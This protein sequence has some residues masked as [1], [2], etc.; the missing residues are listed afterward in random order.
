MTKIF[1]LT[2]IVTNEADKVSL[3]EDVLNETHSI[4]KQ[5]VQ[6]QLPLIIDRIVKEEIEKIKKGIQ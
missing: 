2:D 6:E 4:V 3:R 5:I 1:K